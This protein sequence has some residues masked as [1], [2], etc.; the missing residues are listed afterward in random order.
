MRT[1]HSRFPVV[2]LLLA[3]LGLTALAAAPTPC[4]AQF[5]APTATEEPTYAWNDFQHR[6]TLGGSVRHHWYSQ[7]LLGQDREIKVGI[8]GAY[9]LTTHLTLVGGSFRGFETRAIDSYVGLSIPFYGGG[10]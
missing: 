2:A 4:L 7:E 6:L 3:V 9:E 5:G 10:D 1:T 8:I